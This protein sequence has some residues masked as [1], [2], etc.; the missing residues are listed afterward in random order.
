MGV[1]VGVRESVAV[2]VLVDS[3]IAMSIVSDGITEVIFE[4]GVSARRELADGSVINGK[5]G[6]LVPPDRTPR[7]TTQN[8]TIAPKISTTLPINIDRIVLFMMNGFF[9]SM[10][11][12]GGSGP[13]A[14]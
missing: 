5:S 1:T 14:V 12:P 6:F 4:N 9:S 11:I 10:R 8:M 2:N 13:K 3:I 7:G